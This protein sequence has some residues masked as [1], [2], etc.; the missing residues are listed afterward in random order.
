MQK[1][2]LAAGLCPDLLGKLIALPQTLWMD[3]KGPTSKGGEGK[4]GEE[5]REGGKGERKRKG[6]ERERGGV[7]IA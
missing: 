4:E 5:E 6:R 2:R 7:G 3:L 1:T